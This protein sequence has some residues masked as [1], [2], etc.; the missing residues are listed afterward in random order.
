[1]A[2]LGAVVLAAG[3][4]SAVFTQAVSGA[5]PAFRVAEYAYGSPI[6]L[7]VYLGSR[8]AV[9]L[10]A[11]AYIKALYMAKDLFHHWRAA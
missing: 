8:A 6:E 7:P 9:A 5:Q 1:M 10:V 2:E 11:A 3:P 4:A